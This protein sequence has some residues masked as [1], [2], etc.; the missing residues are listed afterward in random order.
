MIDW[1]NFKKE[2]G[3]YCFKNLINGK[4]YI[5]QAINIRN[6][7]RAHLGAIKSNKHGGLLLYKAINKHGIDNFEVSILETVTAEEGR[8]I[9]AVLDKLEKKYIQDLNTH[10]PNGYNMT[11]GGDAGV[12]GLKM[13][14]EQKQKIST[15]AQRQANSS[16][17]VIYVWDFLT[18]KEFMAVNNS[19]MSR[20]LQI[21]TGRSVCASK[22]GLMKKGEYEHP[23]CKGFIAA[24]NR[25]DLLKLRDVVESDFWTYWKETENGETNSG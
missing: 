23:W 25:N 13:T 20:I 16:V 22:L 3:I 11:L 4:C 8:D 17:N 6:R 12:L 5:G 19:T 24:N 2:S 15:A 10:A 9:K 18:N 7:I 21:S 1:S 14:D